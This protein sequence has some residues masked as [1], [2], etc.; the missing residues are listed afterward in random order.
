[1]QSRLALG[2]VFVLL[3]AC[4]STRTLVREGVPP[5]LSKEAQVFVCLPADGRFEEKSYAGSGEM[6]RTAVENAF[7]KHVVRVEGSTS[8]QPPEAAREQARAMGCTL[9]VVPDILL[10]EDRATEWSGMRDALEVRLVVMDVA[11]G[12]TLDM[13][14][15]QSKS[16]WATLGGDH[17]QDLLA[18]CVGEYVD[19]LF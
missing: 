5:K 11:T 7:K 14:T 19:S 18:P 8:V 15:L 1:M 4:S 16:K 3:A 6:T 2:A 17:P 12:R 10:W 9:V 13:A